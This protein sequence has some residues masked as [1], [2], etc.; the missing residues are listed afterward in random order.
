MW[1]RLLNASNNV[2]SRF[3]PNKQTV[4]WY[5]KASVVSLGLGYTLSNY[6]LT[7]TLLEPVYEKTLAYYS[8]VLKKLHD[9]GL[10]TEGFAFSTADHG[11]HPAHYPWDFHKVWRTY[12]HAS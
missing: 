3:T 8:L 11:L 12:D 9:M 2:Y 6:V 4:F 7:D 5:T 1:N 10:V